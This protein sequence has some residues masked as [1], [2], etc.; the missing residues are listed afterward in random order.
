[1][2]VTITITAEEEKEMRNLGVTQF[3]LDVDCTIEE[4]LTWIVENNVKTRLNDGLD[5]QFRK[6]SL[7]EKRKALKIK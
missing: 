5:T 7:D 1:M 6:L 2:D 3:G 4:V